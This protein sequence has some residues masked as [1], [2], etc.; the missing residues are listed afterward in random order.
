MGNKL[1]D[2]VYGFLLSQD[3]GAKDDIYNQFSMKWLDTTAYWCAVND[4]IVLLLLSGLVPREEDTIDGGTFQEIFYSFQHPSSQFDYSEYG[5]QKELGVGVNVLKAYPPNKMF[6]MIFEWYNLTLPDIDDPSYNEIYTKK[7]LASGAMRGQ[8]QERF[9]RIPRQIMAL[10]HT[11]QLISEKDV[12]KEYPQ[13][14]IDLIKPRDYKIRS[15]DTVGIQAIAYLLKD[16]DIIPWRRSRAGYELRDGQEDFPIYLP[17]IIVILKNLALAEIMC[18]VTKIEALAYL[19]NIGEW[20]A[21]SPF[22]NALKMKSPNRAGIKLLRAKI[23]QVATLTYTMDNVIHKGVQLNSNGEYF[24][25]DEKDKLEEAVRKGNSGSITLYS[26]FGKV[27]SSLSYGSKLDCERASVLNRRI[28]LVLNQISTPS[29]YYHGDTVFAYEASAKPRLRG[30]G[31]QAQNLLSEVHMPDGSR[32]PYESSYENNPVLKGASVIFKNKLVPLFIDHFPKNYDATRALVSSLTTNSQ[33]YKLTADEAESL[34]IPAILAKSSQNRLLYFLSREEDYYSIEQLRLMSDLPAVIGNRSQID[35]RYRVIVMVPN[36]KQLTSFPLLIFMNVVKSHVDEIAVGKQIGTAQDMMFQLK[37]TGGDRIC[38]SMDVSGMDTHTLD[39]QQDFINENIRLAIHQVDDFR[40]GSYFAYTNTNLT[41]IN[42]DFS[43]SPIE[44]IKVSG[45]EYGMLENQDM[46]KISSLIF[47]DRITGKTVTVSGSSFASGLFGTSSQ[48]TLTLKC[49]LDYIFNGVKTMSSISYR[50]MGDDII[51]ESK[52]SN[53]DDYTTMFKEVQT[54]LLKINYDIEISASRRFGVFLQQASLNGGLLGYPHRMSPFTNETGNSLRQDHLQRMKDMRNFIGQYSV[55]CQ[56]EENGD[57]F[58][59][60][61]WQILRTQF[62]KELIKDAHFKQ[63][64]VPLRDGFINILPTSVLFSKYIR[65]G[66]PLIGILQGEQFRIQNPTY[67]TSLKGD[68]CYLEIGSLCQLS[69]PNFKGNLRQIIDV[70]EL[71]KLQL[72]DGLMIGEFQSMKRGQE[73][74]LQAIGQPLIRKMIGTLERYLNNYQK[75]ESMSATRSL[76]DKGIKLPDYLI[77]YRQP[78]LK[79]MQSIEELANDQE[80]DDF[81]FEFYQTWLTT[82]SLEKWM[83]AGFRKKLFGLSYFRPINRSSGYDELVKNRLLHRG[84]YHFASGMDYYGISKQITDIIGYVFDGTTS[85]LLK[86]GSYMN[87]YSNTGGVRLTDLVNIALS[88]Y[89]DGN[90]ETVTMIGKAAG[91]TENGINDLV[92]TVETMSKNFPMIEINVI[93]D[94]AKNFYRSMSISALRE[95][96][97]FNLTNMKD[98]KVKARARNFFYLYNRDLLYSNP[99]SYVTEFSN[100]SLGQGDHVL[101]Y[102]LRKG[103]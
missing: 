54:Q 21:D 65:G 28:E 30:M 34:G 4:D 66:T 97:S 29:V 24:Y 2:L 49:V 38:N 36:S 79:I 47:K 56:A 91:L 58:I 1:F 67:S 18:N 25:E 46:S 6:S 22:D 84:V 5:Y 85:Y 53:E 41:K 26:M 103:S 60:G 23:N 70:D 95:T 71:Q 101:S 15:Q 37:A 8:I 33:G 39:I 86:L 48:H 50:V 80:L 45:I 11:K 90:V 20:M 9:S 102:L 89:R 74:K 61:V 14:Y 52:T 68:F 72:L 40:E 59:W 88:H 82:E 93:P 44:T 32:R 42:Y 51:M 35:R 75:L 64:Q 96:M 12:F 87:V 10:L 73:R 100:G 43:K 62:S 77:Y 27:V 83:E 63:F 3:I 57:G 69:E 92:K 94:N 81:A 17:T 98:S 13:S 7:N 55:R 78:Y 76:L 16:Y 99:F 31:L 19:R